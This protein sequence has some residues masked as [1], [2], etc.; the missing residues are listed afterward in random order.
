MKRLFDVKKLVL[1]LL[2]QTCCLLT[3]AQGRSYD[4]VIYGATPAGI[5]AAVAAS[6]QGKSSVI[7]DPH[8]Q[9][10]GM[11]TSGMSNLDFRT[12]ESLGGF[13]WRAMSAA[14][15][16]YRTTYGDD[17]QALRDCWQ[18]LNY[19]PKIMA[20]IFSKMLKKAQVRVEMAHLLQAVDKGQ[21]Q[22]DIQSI[23]VKNLT[24]GETQQFE[25][26]V[27]IDAS[28]EGD[29][30]AMA[31]EEY[32]IG[33]ESRAQYQEPHAPEKANKHVMAYNF[34]VIVTQDSANKIPFHKPVGY[35]RKDFAQLRKGF[36]TGRFTTLKEV[37]QVLNI[38]NQKAN[39]NDRYNTNAE[40]FMVYEDSDRWPEAT[41]EMRQKIRESAR[42][43]AQ[44]YFYLLSHDPDIPG[45]IREEMGQWGY[46]KDEFADN[47]HFPEWLYVREG[48]RML[49][50]YVFTQHDGMPDSGSV[51]APA[52]ADGIAVGDFFFSSHG[53]H[54][55]E[56]GNKKG[57]IGEPTLPYQIP[58]RA[59]LPK[60]T[61]NLLVPVA[62]SASRVG[63]AS[64]R[65]E[66]TWMALG[67]AAGM[68]AVEALEQ[69]KSLGEIDVASLQNRLHEAG[70]ITFYTSDVKPS[71]PY[72]KAVQFLGNRGFFQQLYPDTL[73]A[74]VGAHITKYVREAFTF[75]DISPEKKLSG[76]D[77][78]TWTA[79]SKSLFG[80][81]AP[82]LQS[83]AQASDTR[84]DFIL[85]LY[86]ALHE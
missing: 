71:S 84:G 24:T 8:K 1:A 40:G 73:K 76:T 65:M 77:K 63:F 74:D 25:G 47:G 56:Q 4:L 16:H 61:G 86:E 82:K 6:N 36:K 10:G 20:E 26:K 60:K 35:K 30:M 53:T 72:F 67:E 62:L 48:R 18:G 11:M 85:H 59:I 51:R 75:H 52:H 45:H 81:Q 80:I 46:P 3:M 69:G 57:V 42:L 58:Y 7:L 13:C 68:A 70:A 49:G 41:H 64:I 15:E 9:S 22:A 83:I 43:K 31:G 29:L 39:L 34:R 19:E 2:L 78:R 44:G 66:P 37:I 38:T 27:F 32:V 17:S 54:I 55:D 50:Q 12:Y 5:A 33:A 14:T 21:R 23:T 28:Y 79:W